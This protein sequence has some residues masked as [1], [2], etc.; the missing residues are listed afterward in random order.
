MGD[1]A[2]I[3]R[4]LDD[5][6]VIGERI[7]RGGMASVFI[8]TD[9]RLDRVVAVKVMHSGLGDDRQFTDRFVREARSAAKLNHPNVVA[10]FDQGSDGDVTYLVMEYVPGQ[11]L[12]DV[13]REEA[14]MSPRRALALMEQVLIALSA[15]HA[16]R[17]IHRDV[18]PENVLITPNGEIK[19]ADFGLARAVSAATTATGGTLIGTVSYLAP[20]IV[21]NEGADAR[22]DVYACGAVLYEMLTG[23]KPHA[24]ESPIQ[25][26]YKHVHED[27]AKPSA[28]I[29]DIPPY[30]DALVARTTARNRDQRSAD[31]HVML[32]QVRQV[33][34]ALDAGL[35]DDPDLTQD[36]LPSATRASAD[37]GEDTTDHPY[38]R[39]GADGRETTEVV[40]TA[41]M[42][43]ATAV[44]G[45]NGAA[46]RAEATMVAERGLMPNVSLDAPRGL[47]PALN[48]AQYKK[49]KQSQKKGR[50]GP[51]LLIA[52]LILAL[53]A[54]FGGWYYGI[55]RYVYTPKLVGLAEAAAVTE[56]TSAGFTFTVEGHEFSETMP[57]G[58]VMSTDPAA[59]DKILPEGTINAVVSDGK[60]R[61]AVPDLN[62]MTVDEATDALRKLH[63]VVGKTSQKF[64]EKIG[65]GD[66][67][68]TD[69][70]TGTLLKRDTEVDLILSK[71]RQP[72]TVVNYTGK[73]AGAAQKALEKAG[74]KVDVK[75]A[76]ND[77]VGQGKVISQDPKSGTKFKADTITLTVSLG[78]ALIAV[79]SVVDMAGN[80]AEKILVDAGFKVAWSP[81]KI[82]DARVRSQSPAGKAR[83]GS[84]ITLSQVSF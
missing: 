62:G 21:V 8:A 19:V 32:Q 56:A 34:S 33:Q 22:S 58:D 43:S 20:E 31:A 14:P 12:R 23:L 26:A 61:Y 74:F 36:L 11:T 13:M 2:L 60:E 71:G 16:A 76:Y 9:K 7:A 53:L 27:V 37:M 42:G 54:G 4:V 69:L 46:G 52:A 67:V 41:S 5:R 82:G 63:L 35:A 80:E 17:I 75:R 47:Q 48:P 83:P 29:E 77:T 51:V 49:I 84:T 1:E 15:A 64:D 68:G 57:K 3:G 28:I 30:V 6:Y 59:G 73:D 39:A 40:H 24:G 10:V 55:G 66:V 81:F 65:K 72:I 38:L 25:V 18:K 44:V 45:G 70:K 78:P 50:R 79:P